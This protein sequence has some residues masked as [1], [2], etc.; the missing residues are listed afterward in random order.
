MS[1]ACSPIAYLAYLTSENYVTSSAILA[2]LSIAGAFLSFTLFSSAEPPWIAAVSYLGG[3]ALS[4]SIILV[5]ASVLRRSSKLYAL[6][7]GVR[8][9]VTNSYRVA[10][11]IFFPLNYVFISRAAMALLSPREL[12]AAI[13]HE[14]GH[15]ASPYRWVHLALSLCITFE[16]ATSLG[17]AI[18]YPTLYNSIYSAVCLYSCLAMVKSSSWIFEHEADRYAAE[19]GYAYELCSSLTKIVALSRTHLPNP[20]A[21]STFENPLLMRAIAENHDV[22]RDVVELLKPLPNL[23]PPLEAR[24]YA[25]LKC[26]WKSGTT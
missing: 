8:V 4:Y 24:V 23:H 15:R 25:M 12:D 3:I 9:Y 14:V 5:R 19:K 21:L 16:I 22:R 2:V 17:Y 10:A 26:F 1:L 11:S 20:D 6:V 18:A 13:M 7:D